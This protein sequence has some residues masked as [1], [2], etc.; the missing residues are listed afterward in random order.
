[1]EAKKTIFLS[2]Y[3]MGLFIIL[4]IGELGTYKKN[5]IPTRGVEHQEENDF[6]QGDMLKFTYK[7]NFL[8]IK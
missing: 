6:P 4:F 7:G 1:L 5:L 3:G 2:R 8:T